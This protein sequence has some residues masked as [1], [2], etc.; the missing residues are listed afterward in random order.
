MFSRFPL[1][2]RLFPVDQ[3][4][5]SQASQLCKQHAKNAIRLG[6]ARHVPWKDEQ[7]GNQCSGNE[8]QCK[9]MWF[10]WKVVPRKIWNS[11]KNLRIW[12]SYSPEWL[13]KC[14][15][16][17]A[18]DTL[19]SLYWEFGLFSSPQASKDWCDMAQV[20][21]MHLDCS[22]ARVWPSLLKASAYQIS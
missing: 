1:S 20:A 21:E 13:S 12:S 11:Y 22:R 6:A 16:T 18:Q 7:G 5:G 9:R 15:H 10:L 2:C 19:F 17:T 14:D 8:L 3:C 4:E